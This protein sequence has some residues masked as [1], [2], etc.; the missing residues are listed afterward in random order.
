MKQEGDSKPVK[1]PAFRAY[2]Q[3][4]TLVNNDLMA[5]LVGAGVAVESLE[6]QP[7]NVLLPQLMPRV[8]HV[9][10]MN[11]RVSEV[12]VILDRAELTLVR[13]AIPYVLSVYGTYL[14]DAVG[15]LQD[16]GLDKDSHE[17]DGTFLRVL[18]ERYEVATGEALPAR[19]LAVFKLVSAVRNR[20]VHQAGTPGSRLSSGWKEL[21]SEA[22][23]EWQR[24][25]DRPL[26]ACFATGR[27]AP[28]NLGLGELNVVLAVTHRL[29]HR[30]NDGLARHVGRDTWA[31][32][33][34][35]DYDDHFPRRNRDKCEGLARLY[36]FARMNY[37]PL[38]LTEEELERARR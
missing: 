25:A 9:N 30:L 6:K 27:Q 20:L 22:Q 35:A 32:L 11:Q 3:A 16:A 29:S 2:V 28:M 26:T 10:R 23:A 33:A 17:P 21:G 37:G 18:H 38:E 4:R 31:R 7:Q 5:L 8:P 14:A 12:V 34:A 36:G 15:L 13:T 19:E 1:S 24:V